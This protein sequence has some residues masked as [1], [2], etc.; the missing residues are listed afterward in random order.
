[1]K[2]QTTPPAVGDPSPWGTIDHVEQTKVD[3]CVFVGTSSHGGYWV[4]PALLPKIPEGW[5]RFA[6][7]CA[8]GMGSQWYEEDCAG[9]AVGAYI[10]EHPRALE[11]LP[12]AES[13]LFGS[14][15]Q[16]DR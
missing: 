4:S 14:E 16:V 6:A 10:L 2:D 7:A 1:M 12:R 9:L 15:Y 11:D 13:H 3:G 5:Q 8:H